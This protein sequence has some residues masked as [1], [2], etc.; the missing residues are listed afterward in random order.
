MRA[1]LDRSVAR[2]DGN[3]GHPAVNHWVRWHA[4]RGEPHQRVFDARRVAMAALVEEQW[5]IG[6]WV[7]WLCVRQGVLAKTADGYLSTANAWHHRRFL[8]KFAGGE[9]LVVAN[10]VLK[11]LAKDEVRPEPVRRFGTPP[12]ALAVGM[13]RV[14]G[15][16]GCSALAQNYRAM[17]ASCFSGLLRGCEAGLQDGVAWRAERNC[18]RADLGRRSSGRRTLRVRSAKRASLDGVRMGKTDTVA[19]VAGGALVDASAELDALELTDPVAADVR[20]ATPAFRGG[21]GKPILVSALRR[22]VKAVMQACGRDPNK[23]GAHSL[24]RATAPPHC[25]PWVPR[26]AQGQGPRRRDP[27]SS[28]RAGTPRRLPSG[29]RKR[30][31]HAQQ[32]VPRLAQG[33]GPQAATLAHEPARPCT[34]HCLRRSGSL[35]VALEASGD[36]T[37]PRVPPH[38]RQTC[39]AAPSAGLSRCGGAASAARCAP[40]PSDHHPRRRLRHLPSRYRIG[41]ATALFAAGASPLVIKTLGRWWSDAYQIYL[42][43]C[44]EQAAAFLVAA[45]SNEVHALQD[46]YDDEDPD[47]LM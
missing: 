30:P 43:A 42:R 7:F 39:D 6:E 11:A 45:G 15:P 23:Y 1:A 32:G 20:G 29:R 12:Q 2:G 44:E 27:A 46:R 5:H 41:G 37:R 28:A 33:Q 38:T 18:T 24:R 17:I 36:P 47:D 35:Q 8:A 26:L 10:G 40:M 13:D 3:D 19:L 14:L 21:D 9:P 25:L 34:H 4:T 22:V 31:R 16:R